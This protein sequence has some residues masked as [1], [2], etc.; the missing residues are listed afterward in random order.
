MYRLTAAVT[1]VH[2][3]ELVESLTVQICEPTGPLQQEKSVAFSGAI[4]H[5]HSVLLRVLF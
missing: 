3:N 4:S 5:F 1:V 2:A